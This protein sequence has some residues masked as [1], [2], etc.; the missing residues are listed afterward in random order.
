MSVWRDE[1][2][3]GQGDCSVGGEVGDMKRHRLGL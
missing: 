1:Y 3:C 2:K